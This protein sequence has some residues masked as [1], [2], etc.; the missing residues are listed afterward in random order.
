M[1]KRFLTITTLVIIVLLAS[2]CKEDNDI[3]RNNGSL[4]FCYSYQGIV[5]K[6]SIEDTVTI[7]M[8][9]TLIIYAVKKN[10][11]SYT[12]GCDNDKINI[13]SK[14]DSCYTCIPNDTSSA[15][16]YAYGTSKS[17]AYYS[18]ID[19]HVTPTTY[20]F[21]TT[22][23]PSYTIDV[24][25]DSL[26]TKIED[27]LQKIAPNRYTFYTMTYNSAIGGNL[28]I[29]EVTKDAV[30]GIF[31]SNISNRVN[32]SMIYNNLTYEF[33]IE[34]E[35]KE[36]NNY[37]LTVDYTEIFKKEYPNEVINK[38]SSVSTCYSEYNKLIP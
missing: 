14:G 36:A 30:S 33:K 23:T 29:K 26:K 34:R 13:I 9:D 35:E 16:I 18:Q 25:K 19:L 22:S 4:S 11:D 5:H 37:L 17:D 10:L 2:S 24:D 32:I 28:Q 12:F 7:N 15:H 8:G 3:I 20:K 27:E 21:V 6:A 31:I 38:V 1:R